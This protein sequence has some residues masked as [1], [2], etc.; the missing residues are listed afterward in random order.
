MLQISQLASIM[1][2][3][4]AFI[5]LN[6]MAL[7]PI[8][9]QFINL[10]LSID[11]ELTATVE[12][13]LDF[14]TQLTNSGRVEIGLGDVNMG[15]F[16]IRA[17][18]TQNVY[19]EL[20]YPPALRPSSP[21]ISAQIPLDLDIAYNNSGTNNVDNAQPLTSESGFIA[22]SENT[23]AATN[24]DIWKQLYIYVYGAIEVG[25]IPNGI[26]TGDIVL[27]VDFD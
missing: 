26:Y 21:E 4:L 7:L 13:P 16:S 15:I 24:S 5:L 3:V 6:M 8:Q 19:I 18:R 1:I 12:Q 14:G 23:Q 17:Y 10:Q 27:T 2:K 20:S 9:A 25:N 22:I 11:A